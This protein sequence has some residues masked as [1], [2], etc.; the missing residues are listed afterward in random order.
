MRARIS[1]IMSGIGPTPASD[2]NRSGLLIFIPN[3]SLPDIN[4][5]AEFSVQGNRQA[6]ASAGRVR[7][8]SRIARL[9]GSGHGAD[10]LVF[11]S[12]LT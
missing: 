5:L 9:I 8:K 2:N 4:Q 7:S 11:G 1:L 6:S 10:F 12:A 3:G